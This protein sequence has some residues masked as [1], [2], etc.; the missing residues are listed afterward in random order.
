MST[1][2][3]RL[4]GGLLMAL[5]ALTFNALA[6]KPISIE[7]FAKLPGAG[8]L[9]VSPG[10][11]YIA[12]KLQ[13]KGAGKLA[14]LDSTKLK[15]IAAFGVGSKKEGKAV[16][17]V[18]WVS[19][20]RV[21]YTTTT[22]Y[23]WNKQVHRGN[24][25]YAA[26][27]DGGKRKIIFGPKAGEQAA[28]SNKKVRKADMG[29]NQIIDL[30]KG[31]DKHILVA[32]YPWSETAVRWFLNQ[33]AKPIVYRVNVYTGKKKKL[34][35]LYMP[36][37]DGITDNAGVVRFSVG[38]DKQS[39]HR[40]AYK[41]KADDEWALFSINDF[42]GEKIVPVGFSSDNNSVYLEA[43]VGDGTRAVYLHDFKTQK[44]TKL[45]HDEQVDVSHYV[46]DFDSS[47]VVGAGTDKG[48]PNYECFDK[49]NRAVK[50][51]RSM[52]A[53]F[54]GSDIVLTSATKDANTVIIKARSETNAGDYY[55]FDR[56]KMGLTI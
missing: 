30:L 6:A 2:K 36:L 35:N 54:E 9:K 28:G 18:F 52:M 19:D 12:L 5:A 27:V 41:A 37:D 24:N 11:E 55:L 1:S 39:N 8:A 15:P 31:D 22:S 51:H 23:A 34:G 47:V 56:K 33:S 32:F 38:I 45:F 25:I 4:L 48:L 42:V 17:D 40:I 16:G 43:N 20:E 10:G 53:T 13:S 50:V 44:T 14:I 26:D 46:Y 49:S 7:N 29:N 21:I 3:S